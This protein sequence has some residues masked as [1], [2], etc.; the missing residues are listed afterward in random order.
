MVIFFSST[1]KVFTKINVF[2]YLQQTY[3]DT[4]MSNV[5]NLNFL[6]KSHYPPH[7]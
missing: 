2:N 1:T 4:C 5:H 7:L 6:F 3:L